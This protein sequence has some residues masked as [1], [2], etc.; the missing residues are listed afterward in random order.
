MIKKIKKKIA[1][2][3]KEYFDTNKKHSEDIIIPE[4]DI[5]FISKNTL[6]KRLKFARF[7]IT[8]TPLE[9]PIRIMKNFCRRIFRSIKNAIKRP[10]I[11]LLTRIGVKHVEELGIKKTIRDMLKK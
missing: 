2:D 6:S 4:K 11:K 1:R 10:T 9:T 8:H 7:M 5:D 3:H